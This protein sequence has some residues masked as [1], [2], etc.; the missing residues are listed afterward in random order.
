MLLPPS[1]R[2]A[3]WKGKLKAE[4]EATWSISKVGL[5]RLRITQPGTIFAIEK[6]G[7]TGDLAKDA[8]FSKT[9]VKNGH[10]PGEVPI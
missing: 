9:T 5:D 10:F 7:L 2:A 1:R 6:D 3:E 4:I 8:T